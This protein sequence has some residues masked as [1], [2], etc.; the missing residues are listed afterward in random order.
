[1]VSIPSKMEKW[2]HYKRDTHVHHMF[3]GDVNQREITE[4]SRAL[5]IYKSLL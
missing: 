1:M 5:N 2:K 3:F 4:L